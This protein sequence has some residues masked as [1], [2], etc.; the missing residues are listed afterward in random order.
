MFKKGFILLLSI[1]L[2]TAYVLGEGI[3]KEDL[4]KAILYIIGFTILLY[5]FFVLGILKD[6]SID[7]TDIKD[8][9]VISI[10]ISYLLFSLGNRN[11]DPYGFS[12]LFFLMYLAIG[13]SRNV[14]KGKIL[15]DFLLILVLWLILDL[16][17]Y[18]NLWIENIF[19]YTWWSIA[20]STLGIYI[21]QNM[22]KIE[23]INYTYYIKIN[24]IIDGILFFVIGFPLLSILGILS[25]FINFPHLPS[26]INI[27]ELL[28]VF[29]GIYITIAIPEE[30]V[31]RGVIYNLLS[32]KYGDKVA[33]ILSSII[34]GLT[35]WNNV[36][37][38]IHKIIYVLLASLAGIIY[39]LAYK[40]SNSIMA[41]ALT[42]TLVDFVWR[43]FL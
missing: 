41:S 39:C 7:K 25:G 24:Y 43:F 13:S 35:H 5:Q 19:S 30:F 4:F 14:A 6:L 37:L 22:R 2:S 17:W 33:I 40:R 20:L 8:P 38:V 21:F 3:I 18:K 32:K 12:I 11:F 28:L 23:N 9:I 27:V 10:S 34:F 1:F 15:Y 36:S 29:I 16:R 26:S 42:H 31:F